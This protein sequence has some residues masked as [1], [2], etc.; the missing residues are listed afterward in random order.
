MTDRRGR[1]ILVLLV[2]LAWGCGDDDVIG[3]EPDPYLPLT[4]P[5]NILHNLEASWERRD[6]LRY[7]ELLDPEFRFYFQQLDVPPGLPLAYWNRDEDSTGTGALLAS[8]EV[9]EIHVDLG[10]FTVEDA[11]R[12][13]YPGARRVRLTQARL[14]VALA[15][16]ITLVVEGDTQD[17]IFRRGSAAAGSDST[18][19]YL[20]EWSDIPGGGG[21]KRQP[22][23]AE[24]AAGL[25]ARSPLVESNSWGRIK[26][27]FR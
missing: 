16:D 9:K 5:E 11:G 10:P 25:A 14:E 13:D 18:R 21:F 23:A 8:P 22:A 7:A 27:L 6:I 4:S 26:A 20:L 15:N 19:W 12:V 1:L 3:P 17:M 24:P 2:G